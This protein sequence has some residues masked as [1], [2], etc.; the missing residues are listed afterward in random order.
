MTQVF[1]TPAGCDLVVTNTIEGKIEVTGWDK[2]QTRVT[3]V[4]QSDDVEVEIGQDGRQVFAKTVNQ[5]G[6]MNWLRRLGKKSAVDYSIYVPHSSNV[7]VKCV[8]G[9]VQVAELEGTVRVENTD[10]S[11]ELDNVRGEVKLRQLKPSRSTAH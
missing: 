6:L 1:D 10:G 2:P 7:K 4:K 5:G 8:T 3:A 11:I 9:P